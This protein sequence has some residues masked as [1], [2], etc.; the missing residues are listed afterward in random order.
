MANILLDNWIADAIKALPREQSQRNMA[1]HF[2]NSF[3]HLNS[4]D[5]NWKF[6][7]AAAGLWDPVLHVFKFGRF[8]LCPIFEDWCALLEL[9]SEGL[10]IKPSKIESPHNLF[11]KL[12]KN[13]TVDALPC[14][15]DK[16]VKIQDLIKLFSKNVDPTN[17]RFQDCRRSALI[18]MVFA[19]HVLRGNSHVASLTLLRVVDQINEGRNPIPTM[20]AET[21][22]GLDLIASQEIKDNFCGCVK[23]LYVWLGEKL[24]FLQRQN[25]NPYTL[26]NFRTWKPIANQPQSIDEW[27]NWLQHVEWSQFRWVSHSC[28]QIFTS[29]YPHPFVYLMGLEKSSFYAPMRFLH[30]VKGILCPPGAVV[31][32]LCEDLT[33]D[34]IRSIVAAWGN[35][36][37]E[38]RF[39]LSSQARRDEILEEPAS[40]RARIEES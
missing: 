31:P 26:K 4:R 18:F 38:R 25:Q 21:F 19:R 9:P 34:L 37:M 39:S 8:E 15:T 35:K 28:F 33:P 12:F 1:D 16:C 14:L 5:I 24:Q 27:H 23:L 20:L 7:Q 17:S 13:E 22:L 10:W 11:C 3:T 36:N 32:P 29:T 40:R 2:I 6:L 30:Q